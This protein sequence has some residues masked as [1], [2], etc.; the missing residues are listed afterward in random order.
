MSA[1]ERETLL[2]SSLYYTILPANL[3]DL[4]AVS[5]AFPMLTATCSLGRILWD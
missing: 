1:R 5:Q 4:P 2:T 3:L